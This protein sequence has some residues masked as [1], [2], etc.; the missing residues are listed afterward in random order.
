MRKLGIFVTV[1]I[2]GLLVA[3]CGGSESAPASTPTTPT[4]DAGKLYEAN[5]VACHGADRQ[6]LPNLGT[7][8]TPESLAELSDT[9]MKDTI[10]DGKLNTTMPPWKAVLNSEEIDA[11]VQF[12]KNTSP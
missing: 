1:L 12:I 6:G 7:A 8:L 2:V 10:S 3:S 5:C 9:E 4:I 11:L